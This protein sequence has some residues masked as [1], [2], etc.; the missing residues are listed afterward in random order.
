MVCEYYTC[1]FENF[2]CGSLQLLV[3]C[4]EDV[5]FS[6]SI[7]SLPWPVNNPIN[8]SYEGYSTYNKQVELLAKFT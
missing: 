5:F 3:F 6:G 4:N 1:V 7:Q 2:L 8:C